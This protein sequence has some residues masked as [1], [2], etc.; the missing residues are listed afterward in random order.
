MVISIIPAFLL[1]S[2]FLYLVS[3]YSFTISTPRECQNLTVSVT[4]EDGEPPYRLLLL[5]F[6]PSPLPDNVEVRQIQDI[7]FG[8][9]ETVLSFPLRYPDRSQFVAVVSD[10]AGFGTGGTSVVTAVLPNDD[11]AGVCFDPSTN[12]SPLFAFSI[13]PPNQIV[14]CTPTRLWW[15]NTTVQ[16]IPSFLGVIPGGRSFVVPEG[17]ITD[18]P[19][20]GTGFSWTPSV[21][22][23]STLVI[24]GGDDRGVG[25]GGSLVAIVSAGVRPNEDCLDDDSPSSTPGSPAGLPTSTG[26]A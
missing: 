24:V 14:Q 6:G 16:G 7:P 1:S 17:P 11:G 15:D 18:V 19:S 4:G 26:T 20:Q 12:V 25:S 5:P 13:N 10:A 8:A 22:A 2:T 9:G 23:G 3:A 21:R